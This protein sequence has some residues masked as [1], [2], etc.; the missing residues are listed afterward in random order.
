MGNCVWDICQTKHKGV[1]EA[2]LILW[3]YP[4]KKKIWL[5]KW[6]T[7]KL[8]TILYYGLFFIGIL[9]FRKKKTHKIRNLLNQNEMYQCRNINRN[10]RCIMSTCNTQLQL[11]LLNSFVFLTS[12]VLLSGKGHFLM[13]DHRRKDPKFKFTPRKSSLISVLTDP[14]CTFHSYRGIRTNS[15]LDWGTKRSKGKISKF[16]SSSTNVKLV[17]EQEL[18]PQEMA[19]WMTGTQ[20]QSLSKCVC[21]CSL[22]YHVQDSWLALISVILKIIFIYPVKKTPTH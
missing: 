16:Y 17:L 4:L 13:T 11:I 2:F 10:A 19:E 5:K 8:G 3:V 7:A 6:S 9:E 18:K 21:V 1:Q 20:S 14:F 15:G 12:F 22:E